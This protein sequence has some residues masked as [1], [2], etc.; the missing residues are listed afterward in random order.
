VRRIPRRDSLLQEPTA[1]DREQDTRGRSQQW[2]FHDLKE[3]L[4]YDV[5]FFYC[6]SPKTLAVKTAIDLD[7]LEKGL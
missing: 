4:E 5:P 7:D 3:C 2:I 1:N 6:P